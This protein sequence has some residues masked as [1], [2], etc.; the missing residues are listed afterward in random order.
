MIFFNG[1]VMHHFSQNKSY[2]YEVKKHNKGDTNANRYVV[3]TMVMLAENRLAT[4][5]LR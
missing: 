1:S 3:E 5:H 2:Q 4:A